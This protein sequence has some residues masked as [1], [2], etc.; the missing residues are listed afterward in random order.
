MT[1][2]Q[3]DFIP[4]S[5]KYGNLTGAEV[6]FSKGDASIMQRYNFKSGQVFTVTEKPDGTEILVEH[7][8]RSP[9]ETLQ[10]FNSAEKYFTKNNM[11]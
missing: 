10:N 5:D 3:A 2:V 1:N 6:S 8:S 7:V 11:I 9:K 4:L